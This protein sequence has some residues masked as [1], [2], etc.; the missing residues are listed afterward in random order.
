MLFFFNSDKQGRLENTCGGMIK[1]CIIKHNLTLAPLKWACFFL[2]CLLNTT[3]KQFN[4]I[5]FG[6][7]LYF[8]FVYGFLV[9]CFVWFVFGFLFVWFCF[10]L[11][12]SHASIIVSLAMI[13]FYLQMTGTVYW[14]SKTILEIL[15]GKNSLEL[16]SCVKTW[17]Y[18]NRWGPRKCLTSPVHIQALLCN[19]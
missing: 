12:Y 17:D 5:C 2:H 7:C 3:D 19:L 10:V 11:I 6:F 15:K 18:W 8:L 9:V 13:G 16:G 14:P 1:T 4:Q